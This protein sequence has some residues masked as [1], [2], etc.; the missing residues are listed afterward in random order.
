MAGAPVQD[1]ALHLA[2][3]ALHPLPDGRPPPRRP[4][5]LPPLPRGLDPPGRGGGGPTPSF[6][7][8]AAAEPLSFE[9]IEA[10]FPG[11]ALEV[12][13]HPGVGFVLA[14]SANGPVCLYRGRVRRPPG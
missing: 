9:A 10:R 6:P 3:P 14:R 2:S 12:S 11:A 5:R 8:P 4:G 13:R 1:R 7:P